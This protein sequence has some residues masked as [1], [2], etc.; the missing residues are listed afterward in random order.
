MT[1]AGRLTDALQKADIP[2][3]KAF[4]TLATAS[5]KVDNIGK[6]DKVG[7][8]L[9]DWGEEV[10]APWLA[11]T[12]QADHIGGKALRGLGWIGKQHSKIPG[13]DWMEQNLAQFGGH[14]AG[15]LNIDPR[16]GMIVGTVLM[17][18]ATDLLPGVGSVL[19]AGGKF[20]SK[21]RKAARGVPLPD[22][23]GKL[24][25][26]FDHLGPD[27]ATA[28]AAL[29]YSDNTLH[30]GITSAKPGFPLLNKF[31]M[32]R[33]PVTG[34]GIAKKARKANKLA[35]EYSALDLPQRLQDL[36]PLTPEE[37]ASWSPRKFDLDKIPPDDTLR[38][39]ISEEWNRML[40]DQSR[41]VDKAFVEYL[42]LVDRL[43]NWPVD[44]LGNPVVFR[45]KAPMT[46][47]QDIKK[48]ETIDAYRARI[49]A[50]KA[51]GQ[52]KPFADTYTKYGHVESQMREKLR[53][54]RDLRS[55]PVEAMVEEFGD[56]F[57]EGFNKSMQGV[58]G[59]KT[60]GLGLQQH[61][62]GWTN[63][64]GS[65][66]T[67]MLDKM[68]RAHK[69]EAWRYI[70]KEYGVSPGFSLSNMFNI[71]GGKG[72]TKVHQK[73]HSWLRDLGFEEYWRDLSK[74]KPNMKPEEM[75]L[76]IDDFME[77][78]YYPTL[79]R[80]ALMMMDDPQG[81]LDLVNLPKHLLK[82]SLEAAERTTKPVPAGVAKELAENSWHANR[83]GWWA[84]P[85]QRIKLGL[86]LERLP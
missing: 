20:A 24:P 73:L 23:L 50:G 45:N 53:R 4:D 16:I 68:G 46:A 42:E 5:R 22:G 34:K 31:Q 77:T 67:T 15:G 83:A 72:T 18:D 38:Y 7:T 59:A 13:Y 71:P 86:Y 48:T 37:A 54:V 58:P 29:K 2:N 3:Q 78:T 32:P 41:T 25:N 35:S 14:I 82:R 80:L 27:L 76:A 84:T 19:G 30:G 33:V 69:V 70:A 62:G 79:Q 1:F 51:G 52:F 64:E 21:A 55:T 12:A 44:E 36:I 56:Q 28:R 74:A 11:R 39:G 85:E 8:G 75:M 26:V 61:H 63:I 47:L 40:D 65:T 17:P 66:F 49:K 43:D 10:V 6:S 57:R 81:G 60:K 9:A